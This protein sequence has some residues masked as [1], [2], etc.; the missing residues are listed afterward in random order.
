MDSN[1]AVVKSAEIL[2]NY[3]K[4]NQPLEK[5][6]CIIALGSHDLRV[7]EYAAQ[8]TKEGWAPLLICSGGL[9]RLTHDLWQEAEALK[10]ARISKQMGV[11]PEHILIEDQS[12]N[13][14]ENILFSKSLLA[15]KGIP[16]RSALL[17]HKPYMERRS[18]ATALKVWP[19]MK[20]RVSSPPISF[21][22]YPTKNIPLDFMVHI[23]VGD[24]QRILVY[25][26]QGFQVSQDIPEEVMQAYRL[27]VDKGY[28][29]FLLPVRKGNI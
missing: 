21:K 2:W 8:L 7:A 3:L 28:I 29:K 9:G 18:L 14:S 13:T 15:E 27:L 11:A 5:C 6:D 16:A 1:S 17:V 23:M 4:L 26:Q 25:P 24:F 12:S 20:F 19:E 22:D 10:F